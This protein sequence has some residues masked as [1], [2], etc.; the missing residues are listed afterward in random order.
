MDYEP[1]LDYIVDFWPKLIRHQSQDEQTKIGLPQP[2]IVPGNEEMFQEMYYWD[3]FFEALGVVGTEYEHLVIDMTEDMLYLFN[4]FGVIPNGSRYYFLSRSQPPF[5]NEMIWLSYDIL[6]KKDQK[7]ADEFLARA[8]QVSEREHE[9][10]WQG[11]QQ[12]HKRL[13]YAGLSR[14]YDINVLDMLASC[15][16]G[17]DHSTRCDDRWL[18]H[19]PVDLNALLYRREKDYERVA[20]M[21]GDSARAESWAARA[22]QRRDTLI[23]LMWDGGQGFFFDYDI[24][25]KACNPT[26]S[27]AGFYPLWAKLATPEQA[28]R[29]VR[30]WL[31]RFEFTGG[32][33]T[34]LDAKAGRQWAYPNGW[35]PLH[36][37][38]VEGLM[39]YGFND[40]AQRI[41]RKWCDN[42]TAVFNQT[43]AMWEKYNV[44]QIGGKEEG[45]LYGSVRGFGWS[46]GVFMNF[47]RRLG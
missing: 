11:T 21:Q 19:L 14:Y 6:V 24:A 47:F 30:E 15:E 38:V 29:I 20:R 10:V 9:T 34:S 13:I 32:L 35:A 18:E 45:G 40:H 41:M 22:A 3:S 2:Y 1:V 23:D 37:I 5:L 44:V 46:N 7:Q 31:P 25:A 27:L 12:P 26:P 42:C 4:R 17:W 8:M 33:V 16:S 39:N 36:W 43:G 28:A